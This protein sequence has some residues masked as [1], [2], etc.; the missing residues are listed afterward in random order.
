MEVT[1]DKPSLDSSLAKLQGAIA[2]KMQVLKMSSRRAI[3]L[4]ASH[5]CGYMID[6]ALGGTRTKKAIARKVLTKFI[7]LGEDVEIKSESSWAGH[8][9]NHSESDISEG[10]DV[11]WY[12]FTPSGIYGVAREMDYRNANVEGLESI[13][14]GTEMG[15]NDGDRIVAGQRG[16]QTIYLWQ[17]FLVKP[18]TVKALI[19]KLQKRVGSLKASFIPS[20]RALEAEG[21]KTAETI[22]A[23][24]LRNEYRAKGRFNNGLN[25]LDCFVEIISNASGA[26]NE[27]MR[28]IAAEAMEGRARAI[29][30]RMAVIHEHPELI[31]QE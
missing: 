9:R 29:I 6:R 8:H 19:T 4:E 20:L 25:E 31:F 10:K 23:A 17:K 21:F 14:F 30:T 26:G 11:E 12:A 1:I 18:S 22:P 5:L 15:G 16:K 7:S 24:A 13:Y 28:Q 27:K 2:A 3:G